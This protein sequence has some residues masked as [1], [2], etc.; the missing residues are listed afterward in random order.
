MRFQSFV[1]ISCLCLIVVFGL[2]PDKLKAED[3]EAT[4]GGASV[5]ALP[6]ASMAGSAVEPL[7]KGGIAGKVTDLTT[8]EPLVGV[9]LRVLRKDEVIA[10]ALSN[11]LGEFRIV[12]LDADRVVVEARYLGYEVYRENFNVREYELAELNIAL[13]PATFYQEPVEIIG[14]SPTVYKR[15]TGAAEIISSATMQQVQPLGTQEILRQAPGVIGFGDDGFGNSRMNIGIRG[16]NPRRSSRVLV[17]EDGIPIQPAI[18]VYPNMYYNPPVERIDNLEILK[19]SASIMYGPQTMGGVINYVT[20]RPRGEFGGFA[21]LAGGENGY[22]SLFTEIGGWGNSAIHPEVQLLLKRGDGF[23]DNNS[24]EQFNATLKTNIQ[25]SADAMLYVKANVNLEEAEATYTG[26]TEYSFKTDPNFNPKDDDL[27]TIKRY[28]LD[29]IYTRN[30][31]DAVIAVSKAYASHFDRRWWREYDVFVKASE[32]DPANP[33]NINPVPYYELGDLIRV[34]GGVNNFGILR[35]FSV[36]GAEHSYNWHHS[37]VG[38]DAYLDAGARLHFERFIDDRQEGS[39]TD[40]RDGAYYIL[41]QADSTVNIV[42]QSHHYETTALSMFAQERL[43]WGDL[44]LRLG[45]R[46]ETFEQ[47]RIDRL[48]GSLYQDKSSTVVLPGIGLNYQWQGFNFYGGVHRGFTPPSSGTLKVL[49]F[50]QNLGDDGLDLRS[51]KSWNYEAGFRVNQSWYAFELTGFWLEIEDLVA[52]GRGT[53]FKNL[54]GA[55]TF[56]IESGGVLRTSQ[57]WDVLPDIDYAYTNLHTEVLSGVVRSALRAGV[58]V[59]LTGNELPYAPEHTLSFGL[60]KRFDFGL[61]LRADLRY[62]SKV[63]TDFENFETTSN[64]GDS[65]PV[66]AYTIFNASAEYTLGDNW[67]LFASVKNL[68]DEVYIASRLHSNPGQPDASASSGILV[69]AR[70]QITAGLQFNF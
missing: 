41:N 15:L 18:Y 64:R 28:A 7:T 10:G 27:F 33:D 59:D 31:G 25:L 53:A 69:G 51:E 63:Y 19:G 43:H 2:C 57:L 55:R 35:T 30:V 42:G 3:A 48:M 61:T 65:G 38:A 11:E 66:P 49:D 6:A 40:S 13:R 20:R 68:T 14:E 23:R 16:L 24:F 21:R 56:G 32:Y 37:L 54:G 36:L 4:T 34:G 22:A 46:M 67:R 39:L 1:H 5:Q 8:G 50:G 26:L 62:V 45:V 44:T 29:L 70:R 58:D 47:E 52:A 9:T 17:L 12:N 60:N